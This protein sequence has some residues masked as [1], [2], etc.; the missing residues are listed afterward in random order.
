MSLIILEAFGQLSRRRSPLS[1]HS[2]SEEDLYSVFH[3][4]AE[5][6]GW[7]TSSA[8]TPLYWGMNEAELTAGTDDPRIGWVQVGPETFEVDS[9]GDFQPAEPPREPYVGV[10][11][12]D[13]GGHWRAIEPATFLLPLTECLVDALGRFGD[14]SLT[15]FQVMVNYIYPR[16]AAREVTPMSGLNWF[17]VSPE[18]PSQ[19]LI[20]F[21]QGFLGGQ[22]EA[23][24][25]RVLSSKN[26]RAFK[27]GPLL[28][29]PDALAV[30]AP[31]EY[32]ISSVT[33]ARSGLGLS[34]TLPEWTASAAGWAL[35]EVINTALGIAPDVRHFTLRLSRVD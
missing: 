28:A 9:P 34:V 33:P 35:A 3:A 29:V 20:S 10:R 25:E 7:S 16:A 27:F 19:A 8:G 24:L 1:R 13:R 12:A 21:D 17:N 30:R 14:V 11:Y 5:L 32:P 4:R 22:S 15:G 26:F 6:M 23:R 31:A 18:P 2:N